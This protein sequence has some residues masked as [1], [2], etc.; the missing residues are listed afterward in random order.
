MKYMQNA[1][2]TLCFFTLSGVVGTPFYIWIRGK[3]SLS[4]F[5]KYTKKKIIKDITFH[6]LMMFFITANFVLILYFLYNSTDK[7]SESLLF[8]NSLQIL[9]LAAAIYGSGMYM[10][11][12]LFETLTQKTYDITKLIHGPIS[13]GI[14][15]GSYFIAFGN[16]GNVAKFAHQSNTN[17]T[18]FPLQLVFI[19]GIFGGLCAGIGA[20][21]SGIS[22]IYSLISV[23]FSVFILLNNNDTTNPFIIHF[24]GFAVCSISV[25][26]IYALLEKARNVP[27]SWYRPVNFTKLIK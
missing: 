16:L 23:I 1:L 8:Y 4:K 3:M 24:I 21:S 17:I 12:I 22:Y 26:I 15:Y 13:H 11:A 27:F 9:V 20:V 5:H 6:F 7:A 18:S 10:T 19:L 14:M 2:L 25:G